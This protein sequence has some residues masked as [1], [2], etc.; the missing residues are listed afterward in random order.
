[1]IDATPAT[2]APRLADAYLE[3]KRTGRL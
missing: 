3:L 1:V 2:L